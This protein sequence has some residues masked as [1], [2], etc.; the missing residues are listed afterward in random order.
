[1]RALCRKIFRLVFS[2]LQHSD[3][4]GWLFIHFIVTRIAGG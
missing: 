1:V 3:L 4:A 2:D